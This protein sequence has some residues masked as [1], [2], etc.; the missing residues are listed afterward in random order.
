MRVSWGAVSLGGLGATRT[1][2]A[3]GGN[4][5]MKELRGRPERSARRARSRGAVGEQSLPSLTKGGE[6]VA[7]HSERWASV[8]EPVV[9]EAATGGEVSQICLSSPLVQ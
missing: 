3:D 7:P 5:L 1:H 9:E 2:Y 4:L 8:A 6:G